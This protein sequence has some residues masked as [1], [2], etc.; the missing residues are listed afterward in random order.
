MLS[1]QHIYHAG[2]FADVHKHAILTR[3]LQTMRVKDLPMIAMD[4]HAG[5]GVYDLTSAEAAKTQEFMKGIGHFWPMRAQPSPLRGYFD[6]I[7]K[8]NVTP[9]VLRYPGSSFI[10]RQMMKPSNDLIC[11]ER[12]PGEFEELEKTLGKS[13]HTELHHDDG[14]LTLIKMLPFSENRGVVVTDP[15]YEIKKDYEDVPKYLKQ[16]YK[17]W[18][19]GTYFLWYP[20]MAEGAH[21]DML[22]A[23][24]QTEMKDI[25]V[26]EI[27]MEKPPEDHYRMFGSGVAIVRPPWPQETLGEITNYISQN[28]PVKTSGH[29]FWLDNMKIDPD[30][31]RLS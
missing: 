15:S 21:H 23:L 28:M 17:K 20:I 4:T 12:H 11:V 13:S 22:A 10:L 9:E 25:L 31:G 3:V 6:L 7:E 8:L 2:N 18:P 19:Q 29:V 24:R 16:A 14:L 30:T 27:I 26:S 5:R 1:Y